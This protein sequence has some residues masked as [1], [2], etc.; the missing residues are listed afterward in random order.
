MSIIN[1]KPDYRLL[2]LPGMS[3]LILAACSSAPEPQA[4]P[5]SPALKETVATISSSHSQGARRALESIGFESASVENPEALKEAAQMML[6]YQSSPQTIDYFR[7]QSQ[8]RESSSSVKE[9]EGD[10]VEGKTHESTRQS[11]SE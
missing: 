8:L 7:F 4:Q 1:L 3:L 2:S 9:Q 10:R 5:D 11:E 6:Q